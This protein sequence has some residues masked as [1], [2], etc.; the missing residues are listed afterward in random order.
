MPIDTTLPL[1]YDLDPALA[2]GT[3]YAY[4]MKVWY[5]CPCPPGGSIEVFETPFRLVK[6]R[7]CCP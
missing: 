1:R 5:E 6:C 4:A 3:A 7:K 2:C